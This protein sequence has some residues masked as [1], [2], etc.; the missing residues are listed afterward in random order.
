MVSFCPV[1]CGLDFKVRSDSLS[2]G[3]VKYGAVGP[4]PVRFLLWRPQN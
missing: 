2:W 1:S 3:V 4:A